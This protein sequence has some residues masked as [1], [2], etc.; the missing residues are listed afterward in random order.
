MLSEKIETTTGRI[1]SMLTDSQK[2]LVLAG[3]VFT[4]WL[5][6]QLAPVL[7]PFFIAALLAYLGDPLVDRLVS[8]GPSRTVVV[9]FGLIIV[10]GPLLLIPVLQKQAT[11]FVRAIPGFLDWASLEWAPWLQ[12]NLGIE[13]TVPDVDKVKLTLAKNLDRIG[14]VAVNVISYA[15]RSGLA[16]AGWLAGI[17]LIPVVTFYLLRDW[18]DFVS[19]IRDLLPRD[20]EPTVSTLA[21]ESDQVLGAFLRGQLTVMLCLGV[22]YSVGLKL[23]GL[24]WSLAIGMLAGLVSFVPYLGV[25]FGMLTA[26]IAVLVQSQDI[27]QLVWVLAVFGAGQLLEGMILTPWLVG[28]RVGLHPVAVIF[29]V[30]A[31][32]QLFGF[33]GIL[34]ALPVAS[35]LAVLLRHVRARYRES[36]FYG[37]FDD[38]SED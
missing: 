1:P 5:L 7:T 25:I 28:D 34:L 10:L 31:G 6:F 9:V 20:I 27:V 19:S 17:V 24:E 8:R 23:A 4:G 36:E 12:T 22:V 16:L 21:R 14:D 13:L 30:L 37:E 35:V 38:I 32:G 29:A 15:S 2:W 11:A 33:M 3:V 26:S 18:D